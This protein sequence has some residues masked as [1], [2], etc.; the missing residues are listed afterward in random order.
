MVAQTMRVAGGNARPLPKKFAF[1]V[2]NLTAA[3]CPAG[4]D[5]VYVWDTKTPGLGLMVTSNGHK[6]FYLYRKING[7]PKRLNLGDFGE[8]TIEQARK[9]AQQHNGT[10]AKGED[11]FAAK[12]VVS[13]SATLQELWDRWKDEHAKPRLRERTIATDE[14]RFDT[15]FEDW[16]NRR[17]ASITESDV[18]SKHAQIGKARG[19]T[20]ANR[21]V[22]LLR[23]LLYFARVEPNPA[24]KKCVRLFRETSRT[25]FVQPDEMP[26]L[27]QSINAE[28]NDAMKDYFLLSV[29]TGQR[30][31]NV[32]GMRWAEIDSNF[33]TWTIPGTSAKEHEAI[34]VPLSPPAVEI[35]KRRRADLPEAEFVFPSHGKT[36]HL[37]EP[38]MAWKSVLKRAGIKDL[39]LHDLRRTLG[40]W[41]AITGASL[42]IIGKSLGHRSS[43]ATEIYA[44]LHLDPVRMS[45]NTAATA[46][47]AAAAG[48]YMSVSLSG[49]AAWTSAARKGANNE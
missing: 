5:R 46:I 9:L 1:N 25:R 30:R 2:S 42:P 4:K 36:G 27:F 41:Q 23:R 15:C 18:R 33:T 49:V 45:V 6:A 35:L 3:K 32:Q 37:V 24:A 44:R 22:Q 19:H 10:I 16:K 31:S 14:S 34:A 13:R 47:L 48:P 38:K 43:T 21:A 39:H 11:P 17:I 20:S 40:S 7:M 26:R 8:V 12:R 29:W 28:P